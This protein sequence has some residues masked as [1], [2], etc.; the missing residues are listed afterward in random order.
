LQ[1]SIQ[2]LWTLY[3]VRKNC[4]D[5]F[6]KLQRAVDQEVH[7]AAKIFVKK[8]CVVARRCQNA[9]RSMILQRRN[10]ISICPVRN[11]NNLNTKEL[12]TWEENKKKQKAKDRGERIPWTNREERWWVA[13]KINCMLEKLFRQRKGLL[14]QSRL[15]NIVQKH[16]IRERHMNESHYS[17]E[18]NPTEH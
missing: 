6:S 9:G 18:E 8:R 10:R 16:R 14:T 17:E 7:I 13:R 11:N 15:P 1:Q 4:R 2:K 5:C 12:I 3:G